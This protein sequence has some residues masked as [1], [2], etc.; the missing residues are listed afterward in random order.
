MVKPSARRAKG[1]ECELDGEM[2]GTR[3]TGGR[4]ARKSGGRAKGKTNINIVIAQKPDQMPMP[5]P[6]MPPPA[7]PIPMPAPPIGA[8]PPMPMP[9]APM[10]PPPGA[11]PM[12]RKAG[13][14]A[15]PKMH[16]GA[17]SGLGR[18]EKIDK[19]GISQR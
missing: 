19:Y 16:Y 4:K 11:P 10:G 5:G 14:R 18:L 17:G 13:G 12:M 9:A 3:P 7:A 2:Q 8:P 15:Y 6:A 1:G